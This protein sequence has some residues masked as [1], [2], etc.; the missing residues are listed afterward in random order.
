MQQW[1]QRFWEQRADAILLTT[2]QVALI[3]ALLVAARWIGGRIIQLIVHALTRKIELSDRRQAQIRTISALLNSVLSYVLLF[4]GIL[5][6]LG[7]LGVNLGPVLATAGVT[8]LAISFGA[9]QLV[10]DVI[11]GFFILV[12][13]QFAVGE[14]VTID[15]IHGVV[16][17]MGM[18]ITRLRD[19]E[20]RLVTLANGSITRVVNH[21]RGQATLTLEVG[22]GGEYGLAQARQWLT[23]ACSE[24]HHSALHTPLEVSGPVALDPARY[25]FRLRSKVT[26]SQL[27]AVADALRAHLLERARRD[28]VPLG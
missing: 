21:S 15:G 3:V 27:E 26:P 22:I 19:D 11:N 20:G 13:D 4:V 25:V 5:S 10:R 9:Q 12:E 18:R 24:F 6:V 7:A 14:E 28:G 17:T 8:G 2:L 1:L 16:E 23:D